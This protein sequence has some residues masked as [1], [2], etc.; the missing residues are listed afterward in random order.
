MIFFIFKYDVENIIFIR[1]TAGNPAVIVYH[2]FLKNKAYS[3]LQ[4]QNIV[5]VDYFV[6]VFSKCISTLKAT[7][8]PYTSKGNKLSMNSSVLSFLPT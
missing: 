5:I 8:V 7:H 6:M 4:K 1:S 3:N 2:F